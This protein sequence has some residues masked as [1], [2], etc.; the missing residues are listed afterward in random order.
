MP[1]SG[2]GIEGI[3]LLYRASHRYDRHGNQMRY[4]SKAYLQSG[5]WVIAP[6]KRGDHGPE[7]VRALLS[8]EAIGKTV[9]SAVTV[10]RARKGNS[11]TILE[12]VISPAS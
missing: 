9:S 1:L 2:S 7:L 3:D 6:S 8:S 4:L 11:S 5:R 10:A 12:V